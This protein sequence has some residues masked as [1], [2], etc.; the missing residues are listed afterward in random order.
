MNEIEKQ[1]AK[2]ETNLARFINVDLSEFL[3]KLDAEIQAIALSTFNTKFNKKSYVTIIYRAEA[4]ERVD[5]TN[6]VEN[7][8]EIFKR[9]YRS[10][11]KNFKNRKAKLQKGD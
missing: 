3:R 6:C 8:I 9:V 2:S 4:T 1:R 7:N 5:I 11:Y 10:I